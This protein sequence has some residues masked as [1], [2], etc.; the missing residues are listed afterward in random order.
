[1]VTVSYN[2]LLPKG[3]R[4]FVVKGE[5]KGQA[6]VVTEPVDTMAHVYFPLTGKQRTLRLTSLDNSHAC[7]KNHVAFANIEKKK[8]ELS[9]KSKEVTTP[10]RRGRETIEKKNSIRYLPEEIDRAII[11]LCSALETA[12]IDAD[13]TLL[14]HIDSRLRNSTSKR[15][16]D[17]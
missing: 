11:A 9:E 8:K 10:L 17:K 2:H 14:C 4:V 3:T 15:G 7:L 16:S 12:K 1:M 6:A 5:Y 13:E